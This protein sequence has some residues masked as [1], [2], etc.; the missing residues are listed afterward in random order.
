MK[1]STKSRYGLRLMLELALTGKDQLLQIKDISKKQDI[2]EKYLEQIVSL[3]KK[4]KLVKATRGARGGYNLSKDASEISL[5]EIIEALEG[6]LTLVD[7]VDH[8]DACE[9]QLFCPTTEVWKIVAGK[10]R[11]TLDAMSLANLLDIYNE[12]SSKDNYVI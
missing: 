6:D 3:L 12:K 7:C 2:S 4:A 5:R 1:L 11:E 8:P 10:L 9:R